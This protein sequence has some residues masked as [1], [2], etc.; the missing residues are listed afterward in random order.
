MNSLQEIIKDINDSQKTLYILCGLPYSGKT[1][2]AKE[3]IAKTA[4]VYVSIDDIFHKRGFD[5]DSNKLPDEQGWESLFNISYRESQNA[6][7]SGS[8]VLYD[9]T[10]H[11]RA[12]RDVLRKIAQ[13][14]VANARVIY[15]DVSAEVVWRRWEENK[16]E[17]DR[18]V[19][20]KKLVEMTIKS[21]EIPTEDEN[22][23]IIKNSA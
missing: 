8:N 14:V 10:N 11:T 19:V 13:D 12:S 23:M 20:A 17:G 9:S 1:Y 3:I 4:C 16:V 22:V 15:V 21:F 5:W 6:L 7:K 2:F 18:P